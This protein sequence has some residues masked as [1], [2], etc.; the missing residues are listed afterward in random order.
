MGWLRS[1]G[2]ASGQSTIC[3]Q[4]AVEG[5]NTKLVAGYQ[6]DAAV[7]VA[8]RVSQEL[9]EVRSVKGARVELRHGSQRAVGPWHLAGAS[10]AA[11]ARGEAS[12]S[13]AGG[14][15]AGGLGGKSGRWAACGR[16]W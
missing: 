10:S 16:R 6:D 9:S 13:L 11:E 4:G 1:S 7:H 15:S 2:R 14:L 12:G 5:K 3:M 8:G